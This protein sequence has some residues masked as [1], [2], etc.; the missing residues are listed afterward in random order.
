[1]LHTRKTI[2]LNLA[3]E[4]AGDHTAIK[5]RNVQY[6]CVTSPPV[7]SLFWYLSRKIIQVLI[8]AHNIGPVEQKIHIEKQDLQLLPDQQCHHW[9][10]IK[11]IP[12]QMLGVVQYILSSFPNSRKK[13][14][15]QRAIVENNIRSRTFLRNPFAKWNVLKANITGMNR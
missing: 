10:M 9:R 8:A 3:N 15:Q 5:R 13:A 11:V 1:M 2:E 4:C 12:F 6:G 14:I 7:R